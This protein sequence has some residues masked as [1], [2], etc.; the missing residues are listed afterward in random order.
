MKTF[1]DWKSFEKEEMN[2]CRE[3]PKLEE[4]TIVEQGN[5][6]IVEWRIFPMDWI[7]PPD[8][9]STPVLVCKYSSIVPIGFSRNSYLNNF[10]DS[11]VAV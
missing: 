8:E 6:P 1:M 7:F 5:V 2:R 11:S 10:S 3:L 9:F 4:I